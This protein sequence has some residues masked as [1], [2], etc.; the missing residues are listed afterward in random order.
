MEIIFPPNLPAPHGYLIQTVFILRLW[1]MR[2]TPPRFLV[3]ELLSFLCTLL[4]I[5][6]MSQIKN[7][8]FRERM[9][10]N[11]CSVISNPTIATVIK[12]LYNFS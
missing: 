10:V 1:K 11:L 9:N 4:N 2:P 5:L 7:Y 3:W 6:F 8:L 12:D